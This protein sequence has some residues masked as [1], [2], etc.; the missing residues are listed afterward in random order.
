[1]LDPGS[2]ADLPSPA[3]PCQPRGPRGAP[4]NPQSR[5]PSAASWPGAGTGR[6]GGPS[7]A[8][9][10]VSPS[11]D[12][13]RLPARLTS[14]GAPSSRG[15]WCGPTARLA[16]QGRG[17]PQSLL[18]ADPPKSPRPPA[19][20][21]CPTLLGPGQGCPEN[22]G[23]GARTPAVAVLPRRAARGAEG[24]A[25]AVGSPRSV[26]RPPSGF[27]ASTRPRG[28][29][30][31]S[32][33]ARTPGQRLREPR[34]AG[35]SGPR[36]QLG[37]QAAAPP[38]YFKSADAGWPEHK[39]DFLGCALASAG[40]PALWLGPRSP[41]GAPPPRQASGRGGGG[42]GPRGA[43]GLPRPPEALSKR[44]TRTPREPRTHPCK[45]PPPYAG[46]S[47]ADPGPGATAMSS[48][49]SGP[50]SRGLGPPRQRTAPPSEL[51]SPCTAHCPPDPGTLLPGRRPPGHTLGLY[52]PPQGGR[53]GASGH[54]GE[55]G[56]LGCP[57][58]GRTPGSFRLN[59]GPP[60]A[61]LPPHTEPGPPSIGRPPSGPHCGAHGQEPTRRGPSP[62][63]PPRPRS[64]GRS[65]GPALG[66]VGLLLQPLWRRGCSVP[67]AA[68][69]RGVSPRTLPDP[70]CSVGS[71]G[72]LAPPARG[73]QTSCESD[74]SRRG[75][76]LW[77]G[78]PGAHTAPG[79]AGGARKEGGS[80][81]GGGSPGRAA[82]PPPKGGWRLALGE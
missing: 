53:P 46:P 60:K 23:E 35:V 8:P 21:R 58:P 81:R 19:P 69:A 25:G 14:R 1:M 28:H 13:T 34:G 15:A 11:V 12:R 54:P 39:G 40:F 49:R 27:P 47:S 78:A 18:G 73:Q 32:A 10:L 65:G 2:G 68:A 62:S 17:K 76:G 75:G 70:G 4:A 44:E 57:R 29:A 26:P 20:P 7:K 9:R 67:K 52:H 79:G 31:A 72:P 38:C 64:G 82:A 42:L 6:L 33:T 48:D 37:S 61:E 36:L 30:G 43:P 56:P 80:P 74:L 16:L 66:R 45:T 55:P 24:H 71:L 50:E 3:G 5:A 63:R 22:R 51:I 77:P 41:D 59:A